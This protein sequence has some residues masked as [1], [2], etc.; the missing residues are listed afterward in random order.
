M[1]RM[2]QFMRPLLILYYHITMLPADINDLFYDQIF[3]KSINHNQI[4]KSMLM[5]VKLSLFLVDS[6]FI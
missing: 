4:F 3:E 1:N 5:W 2:V 6:R